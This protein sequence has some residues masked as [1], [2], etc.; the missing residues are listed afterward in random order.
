[1]T[2]PERSSW[3]PVRIA[4]W[5]LAAIVVAVVLGPRFVQHF[6]P[7]EGR[8]MDFSQ[9]WLSAK[10]YWAGTPVY[11]DQT[12]ALL[13]HTGRKPERAEDMLPWNA[14]PP[15]TTT[16]TLPF[17]KLSTPKRSSHGTSS[18]FHSSC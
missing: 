12:E 14:H 4:L 11:A 3:P 8:F 1:M 10:N 9:E 13:R 16:L 2:P 6:R 7:P 17:G 15:V 18:P 5:V